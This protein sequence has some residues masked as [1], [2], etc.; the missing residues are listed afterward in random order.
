MIGDSNIE[1]EELWLLIVSF[2]SFWE[3]FFTIEIVHNFERKPRK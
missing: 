2:D 3:K 1:D